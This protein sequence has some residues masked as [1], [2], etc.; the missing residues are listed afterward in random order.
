MQNQQ[1]QTAMTFQEQIQ[2]VALLLNPDFIHPIQ[3]TSRLK[4]ELQMVEEGIISCQNYLKLSIIIVFLSKY[5]KKNF[6]I[7][8]IF[9]PVTTENGSAEPSASRPFGISE[10][11]SSST[12]ERSRIE[13]E[14]RE[15][16]VRPNI[17]PGK[18]NETSEKTDAKEEDKKS[19]AQP[20]PQSSQPSS[21]PSAKPEEPKVNIIQ[22]SL[23]LLIY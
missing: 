6:R 8:P 7:T 12:Q 19:S 16:I 20:Q 3:P 9:I 15:D 4:Q 14:K 17:S 23:I 1:L 10:F 21:K 2:T 11:G 22:V 13:I 18:R 5:Q